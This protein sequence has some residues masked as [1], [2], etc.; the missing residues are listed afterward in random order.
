MFH[1]TLTFEEP[2]PLSPE[3]AQSNTW[4]RVLPLLSNHR[5]VMERISMARDGCTIQVKEFQDVNTLALALK[6]FGDVDI[7]KSY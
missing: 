4:L 1:L 7:R 5:G 2:Y 6:P 3:L